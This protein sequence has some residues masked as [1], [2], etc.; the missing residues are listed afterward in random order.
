MRKTILP[1]LAAAA[2]AA[3]GGQSATARL[4]SSG[5]DQ[6]ARTAR[7]QTGSFFAPL[8]DA[9]QSYRAT[10]Y[11]SS[12]RVALASFERSHKLDCHYPG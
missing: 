11:E 4:C 3:C 1:L 12:L 5:R 9:S 2:M 10:F 6:A 8:P 7:A